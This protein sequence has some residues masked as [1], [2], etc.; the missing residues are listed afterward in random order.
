MK[1]RMP[2][3]ESIQEKERLRK[4][5]VTGNG[6]RLLGCKK[7]TLTDL[8]RD[9]FPSSRYRQVK[10]RNISMLSK[11]IISLD[12]TK[13]KSVLLSLRRANLEILKEQ[14]INEAIDDY[15]F[16]TININ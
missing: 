5:T 12:K 16:L 4:E 2:E 10:Q 3:L 7:F 9:V 14:N 15:V 1:E 13:V 8:T 11:G 6:S